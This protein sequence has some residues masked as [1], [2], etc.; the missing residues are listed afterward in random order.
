MQY[1]LKIKIKSMGGHLNAYTLREQTV[2]FVKVFGGDVSRAV[3]ILVDIL[4]NSRLDPGP[5]LRERDVILREMNEVNWHEEELVFPHDGVGRVGSGE[6]DT[7][8]GGE[9]TQRNGGHCA[10]TRT[11]C[12]FL[13]LS[14]PTHC[15]SCTLL[16]LLPPFDAKPLSSVGDT[17]PMRPAPARKHCALSSF[18]A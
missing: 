2:Y 4:L 6:G 13:Q 9:H 15:L 5:I 3:D 18:G 12:T 17:G 1:Q 8:T 10:H 16:L 14:S 11:P 7:W